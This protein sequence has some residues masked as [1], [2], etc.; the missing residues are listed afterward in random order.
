MSDPEVQA[1][2]QQI[3]NCEIKLVKNPNSFYGR[4][5]LKFI[6]SYKGHVIT[7]PKGCPI[8]SNGLI[9]ISKKQYKVVID[10]ILEGYYYNGV[11]HPS[12]RWNGKRGWNEAM[13]KDVFRE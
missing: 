8:K 3:L 13:F 4:S 1:M 10:H 5:N 6:E 2:D 9:T 12:I 7:I 11:H